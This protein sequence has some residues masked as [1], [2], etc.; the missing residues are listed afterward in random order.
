[1]SVYFT[2][3]EWLFSVDT[4]MNIL[5]WMSEH[6]LLILT[7]IL[8]LEWVTVFCRYGRTTSIILGIL[9]CAA[10]GMALQTSSRFK[11]L[12]FYK[13]FN[14]IQLKNLQIMKNL[15]ILKFVLIMNNIC[16]TR[17]S[18]QQNYL[19]FSTVIYRAMMHNKLFK[20]WVGPKRAYYGPTIFQSYDLKIQLHFLSEKFKIC[21]ELEDLQ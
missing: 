12:K 16:Q 3:N 19:W 10:V 2:L 14:N 15:K 9:K 4:N 21:I 5:P 13:S 1:M 11:L 20:I 7:W 8:Y 18:C 17:T 6:F